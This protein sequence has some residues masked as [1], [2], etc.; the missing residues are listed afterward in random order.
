MQLLGASI[1]V[2]SAFALSAPPYLRAQ[3]GAVRTDGYIAVLNAL[4]QT[5]EETFRVCNSTNDSTSCGLA[6]MAVEAFQTG[7]DSVKRCRA[8]DQEA[9]AFMDQAA[10]LLGY[11]SAPEPSMPSP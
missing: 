8:G 4:Q 5:A 11:Q 10:A 1:V 3:S 7:V 6:K 2:L 9:C